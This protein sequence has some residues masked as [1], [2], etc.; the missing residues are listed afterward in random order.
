MA[1]PTIEW[2]F[3]RGYSN[4]KRLRAVLESALRL[5]ESEAL[6][7]Q[8]SAGGAT[9]DET[10]DE[11]A[12]PQTTTDREPLDLQVIDV[13]AAAEAVDLRESNVVVR[14]LEQGSDLSMTTVLIVVQVGL[15]FLGKTADSVWE[16]ILWP[17]IER[18]LG[19]GALGE[20]LGAPVVHGDDETAT[21]RT[22]ARGR[23]VSKK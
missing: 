13:R 6:D 19:I 23:H 4:P 21:L 5:A 15:W 16:T 10:P 14:E 20:R 1:K 7:Q 3:R 8:R 12:V 17:A 2:H 9:A 22:Q 18:E 11:N